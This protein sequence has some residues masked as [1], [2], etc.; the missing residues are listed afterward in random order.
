MGARRRLLAGGDAVLF[1]ATDSPEVR[2]AARARW[3]ARLLAQNA[4]IAHTGEQHALRGA[5][6]PSP[7]TNRTRRVTHPVLIGHASSL[8]HSRLSLNRHPTEWL[9]SKSALAPRRL[10]G[11]NGMLHR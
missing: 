5:P 11:S 8:S 9:G 7:R 6:P 1:L 4:P 3:G 10:R 2:A